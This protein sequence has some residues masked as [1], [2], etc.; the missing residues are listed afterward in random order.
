M[1]PTVVHAHLPTTSVAVTGMPPP[2]TLQKANPRLIIARVSGYGQDGPNAHLPGY[3]S[4]CEAYGGFRHVNGFPGQPPVRPNI[5]L[6]DT[7]AGFHAAFGVLLALLERTRGSAASQDASGAPGRGPIPGAAKQDGVG[8]HSPFAPPWLTYGLCPHRFVVR[9]APAPG[10]GQVVDAAIYESIYNV[11]EAIVPEYD[12]FG[13]F[14]VA[15]LLGG[16]RCCVVRK[17]RAAG[18]PALAALVVQEKCAARRGPRSRA[19]RPPTRTRARMA[20]TSSLAPTASRFL[21]ASRTPS[22]GPTSCGKRDRTPPHG[23]SRHSRTIWPGSAP[24][25]ATGAERQV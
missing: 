6:G 9:R 13:T 7:L 10:R 3:A 18:N 15:P 4:V 1:H 22:A 16:E 17:L 19:S 2:E 24:P 20:A 8:M 12:R 5:S 14:N 21:S 25:R 11:M 23:N